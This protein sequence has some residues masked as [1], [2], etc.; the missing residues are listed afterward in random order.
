[1]HRAFI[2]CAGIAND[3]TRRIVPQHTLDAA[4]RRRDRPKG[5]LPGTG[6]KFAATGRIGVRPRAGEGG[7]F[8]GGSPSKGGGCDVDDKLDAIDV[9]TKAR[10][11][12]LVIADRA[13][14]KA[15]AR[16][17]DEINHDERSRCFRGV[18]PAR[19]SSRCLRQLL[20]H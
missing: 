8:A 10:G 13:E 11:S 12:R 6:G 1:M 14:R 17:K 16:S 19:L 5:Q 18:Q 9:D 15:A 4:R 3:P 20:Q 7:A 2:A